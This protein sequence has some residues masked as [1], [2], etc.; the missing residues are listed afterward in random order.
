MENFFKK[1][2]RHLRKYLVF[3]APSI[4]IIL[5]T[6]L[7]H[8]LFAYSNLLEISL[9][10]VFL[11][12]IIQD[13]LLKTRGKSVILSLLGIII[14]LIGGIVTYGLLLIML[15]IIYPI[16]Y[17]FPSPGDY[18]PQVQN[19]PFTSDLIMAITTILVYLLYLYVLYR[20]TR[21]LKY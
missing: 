20:I 12:G 3:Y 9:V 1:R 19:I 4:I 15:M 21:I 18:I 17:W 6:R 13:L 11:I 7:G 8:I 14:G 16:E 5:L 2:I 10:L